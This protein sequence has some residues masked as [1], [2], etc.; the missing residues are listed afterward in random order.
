MEETLNELYT[1]CFQHIQKQGSAENRGM[2]LF[3][4]GYTLSALPI[5]C[6][7]SLIMLV[8]CCLVYSTDS[9]PVFFRF[10]PL[11]DYNHHVCLQFNSHVPRIPQRQ[12]EFAS[13]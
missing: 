1:E 9:V 13:C 8:V 6:L 5:S 7:A 2:Y 10:F 4:E 3:D 12:P 11:L